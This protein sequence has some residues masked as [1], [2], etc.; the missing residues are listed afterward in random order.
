MKFSDFTFFFHSHRAI[1]YDKIIPY[2][3]LPM[4]TLHGLDYSLKIKN[5]I[6]NHIN[7]AQKNPF[8]NYYFMLTI[9]YILKKLFL[10]ILI[11]FLILGSLH[12]MI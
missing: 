9:H 2:G 8:I 11:H 12:T 1:I 4:K 3:G 7:Q 6:I 5:T 10:N